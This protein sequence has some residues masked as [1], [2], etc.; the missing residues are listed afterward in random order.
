MI[1][2]PKNKLH[3]RNPQLLQHK[4][5][6]KLIMMQ[7]F[8]EYDCDSQMDLVRGTPAATITGGVTWQRN[9]Y[10]GCIFIPNDYDAY[11]THIVNGDMG[12]YNNTMMMW[13]STTDP[14]PTGQ[15]IG[16]SVYQDSTHFLKLGRNTGALA[17]FVRSEEGYVY[18]NFDVPNHEDGHTFCLVGTA[19]PQFVT[20]YYNG[21]EIAQE[22]GNADSTGTGDTAIE[23]GDY[24]VGGYGFDNGTITLAAV[25]KRCLSPAEVWALYRWGPNM[26]G[27]DESII[28]RAAISA[29]AP[30]F[31]AG[32]ALNSN[33]QVL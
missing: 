14:T 27:S 4:I 11:E 26:L 19:N 29:G 33:S 6:D 13:C 30:A 28:Y 2:L 1:G 16:L 25:W 32:W 31:K 5:F 20:T 22:V 15:E 7:P 17:Y 9:E 24:L 10:G 8:L 21:R 3:L 12:W 23:I 18:P